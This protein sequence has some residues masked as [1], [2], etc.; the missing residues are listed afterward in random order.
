MRAAALALA[1]AL[2]PA[3]AG[4]A[5]EPSDAVGQPG[6]PLPWREPA[7][8]A[9]MFLQLPFEAPTV[10]EARTFRAELQLQ[11]ANSVLVGSTP[12]LALDVDLESA[13]LLA[14]LHYGLGGGVEVQLGVP[15]MLDAGGFLDGPI[16]AVERVFGGTAMPG[17]RGRP[18]GL[19]RFR[20]LRPD[21]T[22]VWRDGP[23]AGLGDV[24]AGLKV[25][26]LDGAGARP[27][28]AV[29]AAVKAPTGRVP[30]GSGEVDAGAGLQAGWSWRR[31]GLRLQLDAV[32]PTAGLRAA[33]VS[34]RVYGAG[35]A[36]VAVALSDALALHAQW[37]THLSPFAATG[38]DPL[39]ATT[40]YA[41]V[42]AS[43]A[44]SRSLELEAAAAEN[45][46]SPAWGADFTVL[47]GLRARP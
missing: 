15:A 30:D 42:G 39:D 34:T 20:L 16:V 44:L 2:P 35:Q 29:R 43:V 27:E 6:A 41:L 19:A 28:V 24:W 18:R 33:R 36:D 22:G 3:G 11:Y 23:A 7:P 1:L 9:R 32:A 21:G 12:S 46:F 31:L 5:G 17:R 25:H 37:A 38:L 45:V 8:P 13:D 10:V 4:G 47:L 40:H 14:L 26:L